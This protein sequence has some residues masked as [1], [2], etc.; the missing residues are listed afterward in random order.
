MA[1]ADPAVIARA[2]TDLGEQIPLISNHPVVQM[3]VQ[4]QDFPAEVREQLGGLQQ[5]IIQFQQQLQRFQGTMEAVG[6]RLD[7]LGGR[8]DQLFTEFVPPHTHVTIDIGELIRNTV[9][10]CFPYVYIIRPKQSFATQLEST[11]HQSPGTICSQPQV[12]LFYIFAN[13]IQG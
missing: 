2:F 6:G 3:L 13:V 7:Q 11:L 1:Q 12:I 5:H 10:E 9:K 4:V 8:L